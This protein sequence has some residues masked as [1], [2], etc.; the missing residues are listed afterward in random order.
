MAEK[1]KDK[2]RKTGAVVPRRASS[3]LSPW[4]NVDRMFEDFLERRLRPF[5][6]D[7]WWP[8][9]GMEVPAPALDVYEEKDDI[10]VKA[11][12]PG[13]EKDNIEVNLSD[14]RLSIK[15]E[16]KKEEEVNKK[17]AIIDRSGPMVLLF[18]A[19]SYRA[20]CKQIKSRLLSRT[21]C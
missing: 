8:T 3:E 17:K 1:A 9:A 18:E 16:K 20:K 2:A 10:V 21:E 4:D 12:L 5:S 7:R 6:P 11:E 15:G 13:L 19:S 14:N